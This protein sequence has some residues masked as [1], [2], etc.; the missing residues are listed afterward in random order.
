MNTQ[1]VQNRALRLQS[2]AAIHTEALR[3]IFKILCEQGRL[4]PDDRIVAENAEAV[5]W[6]LR[7]AENGSAKELDALF[8][9]R[10]QSIPKRSVGEI[11]KRGSVR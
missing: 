7:I 11:L 1:T 8:R 6:A 2:Q 10:G 4:A 5:R 9:R 3:R